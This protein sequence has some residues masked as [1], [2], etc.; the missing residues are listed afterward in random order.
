MIYK[1]RSAGWFAEVGGIPVT[2][3]R[4]PAGFYGG[5]P[6]API[7]AMWHFTAGCGGGAEVFG[8]LKARGISAHF[9]VDRQGRIFQYV[10]LLDRAAHAFDANHRYY[11]VEHAATVANGPCPLTDA[12][13]AASAK[14]MAGLVGFIK[15][16]WGTTVP[17]RH[18][19]GCR[20]AAGFK[21]HND[22]LGSPEWPCPWNPNR[23][24]DGLYRWSW[25]K[26]LKAITDAA[27][28][29]T[30]VF[31]GRRYRKLRNLLRRLRRRLR[32]ARGEL[33]VEVSSR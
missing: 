11:G 21:Q 6:E 16:H 22:G 31:Q 13:L 24:V 2:K 23:H 9:L 1:L 12:Q 32:R 10:S 26:Y 33:H 5:W 7:G 29:T 4:L 28:P 27:T 30:F 8:V 19:E 25:T 20:F 18:V 14:L 3:M 17:I 15:A